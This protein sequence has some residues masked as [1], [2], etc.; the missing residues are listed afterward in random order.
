MNDLP[1]DKLGPYPLLQLTAACIVLMGLALAV[2][3]GTKD[4]NAPAAQVQNEQRYFFDGPLGETLKLLRDAR[5]I[6]NEIKEH[7]APLGEQARN[8]NK[9]LGEIKDQIE[10]LKDIKARRR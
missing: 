10:A 5:N 6:L 8:T 4:R 1:I 9:E 7:V 3:R 2:Y